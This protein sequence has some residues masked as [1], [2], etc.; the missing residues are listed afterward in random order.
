ME[1][2]EG[3]EQLI[4]MAITSKDKYFL[5]SWEKGEAKFHAPNGARAIDV[6][7]EFLRVRGFKVKEIA[8]PELTKSKHASD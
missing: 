7:I 3:G 1:N 4:R 5:V 8:R 2:G 6:A